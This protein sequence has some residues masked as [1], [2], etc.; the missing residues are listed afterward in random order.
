MWV[1]NHSNTDSTFE[2]KNIYDELTLATTSMDIHS[3]IMY[4]SISYIEGQCEGPEW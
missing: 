2:R 4:F 1:P 3:E